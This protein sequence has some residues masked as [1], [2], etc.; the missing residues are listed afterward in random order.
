MLQC[1]KILAR[2]VIALS[3]FCG[4]SGNL[5]T[6]FWSHLQALNVLCKFKKRLAFGLFSITSELTRWWQALLADG[7]SGSQ[8]IV[9]IKKKFSKERFEMSALTTEQALIVIKLPSELERNFDHYP[10][11][12]F[13]KFFVFVSPSLNRKTLNFCH[14]RLSSIK[15]TRRTRGWLS[16][17]PSFC[18]NPSKSN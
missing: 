5:L 1:R 18:S 10:A 13:A 7:F 9:S 16:F 17:H 15:T 2:T 8:K 12:T 14:K 3:S 4:M 6:V 11:L